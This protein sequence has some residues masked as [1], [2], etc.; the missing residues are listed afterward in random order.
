MA[1]NYSYTNGV[2]RP[3]EGPS[4]PAQKRPALSIGSAIWKFIMANLPDAP[5]EYESPR[6]AIEQTFN[7]LAGLLAH[8][9]RPLPTETGDGTYLTPPISTGLLKDLKALKIE[10]V[11]TL[12]DV[13]KTKIRNEGTD[14]RDYLMERVIQVIASP[15]SLKDYANSDHCLGGMR[16]S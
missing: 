6:E 15:Q 16:A 13:V 3:R 1:H 7:S 10:D 2:V 12:I 8:A 4:A 5:I 11:D 9:K 14:D